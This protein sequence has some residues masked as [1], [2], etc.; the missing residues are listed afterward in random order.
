MGFKGFK[1]VI[2][3]DFEQE[4]SG[5][6]KRSRRKPQYNKNIALNV[7]TQVKALVPFYNLPE[8]IIA[9]QCLEIGAYNMIEVTKDPEK[10]QEMKNHLIRDHYNKAEPPQDDEITLRMGEKNDMW[11][12]LEGIKH[13]MKSYS[14]FRK[15]V[16][17][18]GGSAGFTGDMHLLANFLRDFES[19]NLWI[20][21]H[22]SGG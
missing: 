7:T 1:E 13:I 20:H 19:F 6:R 16:E 14:R 15:T 12:Y 5:K 11:K 3:G 2:K 8:T 10:L 18:G 17:P 9:E 4:N 21:H 22:K